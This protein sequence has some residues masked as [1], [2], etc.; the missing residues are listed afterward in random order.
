MAVKCTM[1]QRVTDI[2]WQRERRTIAL[3]YGNAR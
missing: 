1:Q 2:E 3:C